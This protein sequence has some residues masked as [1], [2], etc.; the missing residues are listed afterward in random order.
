MIRKWIAMLVLSVLLIC[1]SEYATEGKGS[2]AGTTQTGMLSGESDGVREKAVPLSESEDQ[3]EGVAM[4]EE[5]K[6]AYETKLDE[7]Y[8][9]KKKWLQYSVRDLD[10]NGVP[11]L[12]FKNQMKVTIY[13]YEQGL[14]KI[15]AY[16]FASGTTMFLTTDHA[17]YPGILYFWVG[18]GM[19]HYGYLMIK[20][21]SLHREELWNED[22]S[23]I[24]KELGEDRE[25]IMEISE[26]A[27]LIQESKKA[28]EGRNELQFQVISRHNE[29]GIK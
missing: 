11:E 4:Q 3:P 7:L 27:V 15:G 16:D 25:R 9:K 6:A 18:G 13:S 20:D 12:L 23:G 17:S 5:W 21:Q 26:D 19:E 29:I 22:Y 8:N 10:G 1:L 2:V 14:Q 28:Y 24:S